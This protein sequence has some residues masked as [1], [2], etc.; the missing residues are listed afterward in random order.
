M[1]ILPD[2]FQSVMNYL[3]TTSNPERELIRLIHQAEMRLKGE[4]KELLA[5]LTVLEIVF[6]GS[7]SSTSSK[8]GSLN[9]K[10]SPFGQTDWMQ[11]RLNRLSH[12]IQAGCDCEE[13]QLVYP[14]D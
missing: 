8:S 1:S 7:A 9:S 11:L 13:C 6:R 3:A 2:N 10:Q 14:R 4:E 12:L 5:L